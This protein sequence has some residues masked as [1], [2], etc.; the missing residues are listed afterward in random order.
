ADVSPVNKSKSVKKESADSTGTNKPVNIAN[1][2]IK[3]NDAAMNGAFLPQPQ[4]MN[5]AAGPQDALLFRPS[6]P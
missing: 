3:K 6:W 2:G 5:A 1:T 4:G